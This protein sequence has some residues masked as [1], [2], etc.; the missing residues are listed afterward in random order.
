MRKLARCIDARIISSGEKLIE[1]QLYYIEV[2]KKGQVFVFDKVSN[3]IIRNM[4]TMHHSTPYWF[5][6][7]RFNVIKL[8]PLSTKIVIL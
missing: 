1:G 3:Q 7:S 5:S 2:I 8:P 6:A 4:G